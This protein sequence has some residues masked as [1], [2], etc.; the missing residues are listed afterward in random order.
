MKKKIIDECIFKRFT[1]FRNY[2][3]SSY[4]TIITILIIFL[5]LTRMEQAF[6][7]FV[8]IT[9]EP[10]NLFMTFV[11]L[12]ALA[13]ALSHFPIYTYFAKNLNNSKDKFKFKQ[14][15]VQLHIFKLWVYIYE[16]DKSKKYPPSNT[17]HYLRYLNGLVIYG[18]WIFFIIKTYSLNFKFSGFRMW[19]PYLV[20]CLLAL[21]IASI[22]GYV[23]EKE[24]KDKLFV[25]NNFKFFYHA[26]AIIFILTVVFMLLTLIYGKISTLGFWLHIFTSFMFIINYLFFRLLRYGLIMGEYNEQIK[27]F[28]FKPLKYFLKILNYL[29]YKHENYYTYIFVLNFVLAFS[30]I[31]YSTFA[32][33]NLC[34]TGNG[35]PILLAF[36]YFYY[37]LIAMIK[38]YAYAISKIKE[39]SK[40][41]KA[42]YCLMYITFIIII[43][44]IASQIIKDEERTHELD[45]VQ[46]TDTSYMIK[47]NQFFKD[48]KLKNSDT[49]FFIA[50][51]GGGLKANVWTLNVL[52]ELQRKTGGKLFEQT[53][54]LSG[55]SGGSLG[56]ALY[57]VLYNKHH[58]ANKKIKEKI[59]NI[60]KEN[61]TGSDLTLTLGL[62]FYRKIWPLN[63]KL[64]VRDRA[65]YSMLRYQTICEGDKKNKLSK[66][67]FRE[68]WI[69]T[70]KKYGYCPSLI[71]NT[72]GINGKRGILWSVYS[73]KFDS[74]FH[75][76]VNLADL[77]D[78]KTLPF[79]QAVSTTNRF[80]IFS[81]AAKIKGYGYFIDAGI[82]DNHGLLGCL[83]LYYY[84]LSHEKK[85]LKD[86]KV[87]FIE[88]LNSKSSYIAAILKQ[89]FEKHNK[90][91]FR[92]NFDEKETDNFIADINAAMDLGKIPDYLSKFISYRSKYDTIYNMDHVIIYMPHKISLED[93]NNY[94]VGEIKDKYL[95]QELNNLLNKNNID[96]MKITEA[97]DHKFYT[98]W[99]TYEPMLS[100]HLSDKSVNYI[101]SILKHKVVTDAFLKIDNLAK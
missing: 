38:K 46:S 37:C 101:D 51:Q 76:A 6:T 61:Y 45:M 47:E 85:P 12:N 4:L 99:Q 90:K 57:I 100:R 13:I 28:R 82:I 24:L 16:R 20:I 75:N 9:N 34:E 11:F 87:V 32:S 98:E 67:A 15:K 23:K 74:I 48:L 66:T 78:N 14:E 31:I 89:F 5:L 21:I 93:V 52:N 25:K 54:A 33:I 1:A 77:Y 63:R 26:Y 17:A 73:D 39:K 44:L 71:M 22:Y 30:L 95:K 56:L 91:D 88:I 49:L 36:L 29:F 72:A 79:Y 35:I 10:F 97:K 19:V 64:C 55:A 92:K 68:F 59:N 84:L 80:P 50:S 53:I 60:A 40:R 18:I 2:T 70:Y 65:Y 69:N 58:E 83:D 62:D 96:I 94:L 41:R 3:K 81:P 8:A 86:K 27:K 42:T 7:L 43:I